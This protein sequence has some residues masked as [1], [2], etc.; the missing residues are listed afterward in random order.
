[1]IR[2][3][4]RPLEQTRTATNSC[5]WQAET[6]V[7]GVTYTA[8]SRRGAVH[9]LARVLVEAG[10]EDQ[11]MQVHAEGL[12]GFMTYRSFHRAAERTIEENATTPVRTVRYQPR[13]DAF[14]GVPA[15]DLEGVT[16]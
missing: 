11:P 15:G 6:I 1:M 2:V 7:A 16:G 12:A 9:A 4:Q 13:E 10:I 5:R 14:Q 8:S 3:H